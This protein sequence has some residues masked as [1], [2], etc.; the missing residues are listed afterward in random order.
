MSLSEDKKLFMENDFACSFKFCSVSIACSFVQVHL[1]WLSY[2]CLDSMHW[3]RSIFPTLLSSDTG[4][5]VT[6]GWDDFWEVLF[7]CLPSC[8][9]FILSHFIFRI[10]PTTL[11]TIFFSNFER[12]NVIFLTFATKEIKRAN[13]T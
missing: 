2:Q 8:F 3:E 13:S 11:C 6:S 7:I 1:F 5:L 4:K 12:W 10:F 9:T